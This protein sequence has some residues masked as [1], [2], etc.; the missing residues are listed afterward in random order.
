MVAT[1]RYGDR[2]G[3]QIAVVEA[4]DAAGRAADGS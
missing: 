1:K 3:V 4:Q 2:P